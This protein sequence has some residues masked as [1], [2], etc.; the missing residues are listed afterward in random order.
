MLNA[1][2]DAC[3]TLTSL[4]HSLTL[5]GC[6]RCTTLRVAIRRAARSGSR[7]ELLAARAELAAHKKLQKDQRQL[8]FKRRWMARQKEAGCL[9]IIFDK[10][11]SQTTTVTTALVHSWLSL[12]CACG[13]HSHTLVAL[14]LAHLWLLLS[15]TRGTHSH[16]LALSLA[17]TLLHAS[18]R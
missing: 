10:W 9:S 14:T 7:A 1:D 18:T 3:K 4:T 11:N 17:G 6:S 5:Q 13:S 8:Y 2:A 15:R 16:S 12:L